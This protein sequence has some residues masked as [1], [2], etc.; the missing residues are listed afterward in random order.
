M[1]YC[2]G[3]IG[4]GYW[5]PT[6][7]RNFLN[8][9]GFYVKWVCDRN[10]GRRESAQAESSTIQITDNPNEILQDNSI[11]VVIIA[12][13]ASTHYDLCREALLHGRHVFIEKPLAL[14]FS[15]AEELFHMS[16]ATGKTVFVD[17]TWLFSVGYRKLREIL[18]GGELGR[19]LR[20]SSRR[21]D[22]GL[23]QRDANVLW[24]LMYHDVYLLNDLFGT[25]PLQ[26][27]AHGTSVV[28]PGI[29]DGACAT[30]RYPGGSQATVLCDLYFPEKVREF[31]VQCERGILVWDE[32]QQNRLCSVNRYATADPKTGEVSYYG[33][34][35]KTSLPL[36]ERETLQMVLD[37]F[38]KKISDFSLENCRAALLAVETI[39]KLSASLNKAENEQVLL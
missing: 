3:I 39:E 37:E 4:Y 28:L 8:H 12:T 13:Q 7:L 17:H 5:G 29:A 16:Q 26:V 25:A 33:D 34:S 15:E 31:I 2:V 10:R 18:Q 24:H 21:C 9:E 22:F 32:M 1:R 11:D 23:F 30:L 14:S 20:I 27:Q 36:E 19:V 35:V 6:L 38:Y